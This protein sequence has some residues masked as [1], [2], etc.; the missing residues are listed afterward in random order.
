MPR[1]GIAGA[2]CKAA[3]SLLRSPAVWIPAL[4][5]VGLTLVFRLTDIDTACVKPFFAGVGA[6]EQLHDRWPSMDAQPWKALYDWGV[7]PAWILG[8]GGMAVWIASFFWTKLESWRDPGLFYALLLIVGPGLLVNVLLK[9]CWSRPRPHATVP[10]GGDREFLLVWDLG[11]GQDD[12]SFPSG[13]AA[14][15]FYL[16]A[17]ALV[18]YRRRPR[19]ALAF[20]LLG[21]LNGSV[22]GLARMVAGSHF[23]SD[24]LWSG[25]IIYFTALLIAA[26]F[27][28]WRER[29]G[30]NGGVG[31]AI[32]KMDG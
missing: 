30:R 11:S 9:P 13:H 23:P 6:G 25:G 22:I 21:L 12:S 20:L 32:G 8:C 17:P 1:C 15:G 31:S 28:S 19:L 5:L 16:M 26:P 29:G 10:F 4:V 24:V 18:F 7:Y 14:M 2:S 27:G 3:L